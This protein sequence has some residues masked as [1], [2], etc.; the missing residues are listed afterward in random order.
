M[1][2]SCHPL[3]ENE[4]Y[5]LQVLRD[6]EAIDAAASSEFDRIASLAKDEFGV[7]SAMVAL[8]DEDIV[9][10]AAAAGTSLEQVNRED[11]F[12]AYTVLSDAVFVVLDAA[13]HPIFKDGKL[14]A[15]PFNIR[16][17][18]GA[19][20]VIDRAVIG[21]LCLVDPEPRTA[22]GPD[23]RA[24]L[25]VL[26]DEAVDQMIEKRQANSLAAAQNARKLRLSFA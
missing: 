16:F 24:R 18:A 7:S 22:F 5:R 1:N 19:P 11:A 25:S 23:E 3:A 6:L 26:A 12:C 20:L 10:F 14:V 4:S 17:Y 8:V 9:R 21:A 13:A 2:V 15:D